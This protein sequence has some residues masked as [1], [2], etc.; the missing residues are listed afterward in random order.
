MCYSD[1]WT[2]RK[3][4]SVR[5]S[6]VDCKSNVTELTN[7]DRGNKISNHKK[8]IQ[9]K[10]DSSISIYGWKLRKEVSVA[11]IIYFQKENMTGT[12]AWE[13]SDPDDDEEV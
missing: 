11:W 1:H 8:W 9:S 10:A 7:S 4:L 12:S 13:E 5:P 3:I 2:V 6:V